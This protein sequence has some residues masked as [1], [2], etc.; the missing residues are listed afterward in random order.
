MPQS[1]YQDAP[2][3]ISKCDGGPATAALQHR[4]PGI[5]AQASLLQFR[6]VA[7]PA[8]SCQN[9]PYTALEPVNLV[10]CLSRGGANHQAE[11]DS[12]AEAGHWLVPDAA[13][14]QQRS[15][16]AESTTTQS[17]HIHPGRLRQFASPS[18]RQQHRMTHGRVV[19]DHAPG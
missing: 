15:I 18:P 5:E 11:R 1:L 3:R 9:W 6:T 12:E 8:L 13:M 7:I 16:R 14:I 4:F 17:I 19:C 10:V 2:G